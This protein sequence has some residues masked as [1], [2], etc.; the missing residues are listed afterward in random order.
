MTCTSRRA[1]TVVSK[2][3]RKPAYPSLGA[4]E[5]FRYDAL[6]RRILVRSRSDSTC[7]SAS[8]QCV[9][10]IQR[11]VYD[12]NN[13]LYEIQMPGADSVT[14]AQLWSSPH[15]GVSQ[16]VRLRVG[17]LGVPCWSCVLL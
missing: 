12:G 11:T 8:N 2:L 14:A 3:A 1:G 7:P 10:T 9:S 5:E 6:G 13:V 4:F 16:S 15:S 17:W